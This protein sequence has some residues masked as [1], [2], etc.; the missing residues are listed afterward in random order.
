MNCPI[1]HELLVRYWARDLPEAEVDAIDEHLFGCDACFEASSRVAALA[2]ALTDVIPPIAIDRDLELAQ[3]RGLRQ[4]SNDFLPGVPKE[5]WLRP[6]TDLLVHRLRLELED[7]ERV[8]VDVLLPNGTALLS[9]ADAPFDRSSGAVLIACRRHFV[10][11]FPPDVD[12]VVHCQD[13]SGHESVTKYTVLHRV[14]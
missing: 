12:F 4:A 1:P 13:R 10:E 14:G 3:G 7:V 2:R 9:F 5:A 11:Q 6:G 8:S